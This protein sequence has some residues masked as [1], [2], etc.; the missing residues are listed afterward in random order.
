MG[1]FKPDLYRNFAIGFAI[2]T[3]IVLANLGS[4]LVDK[5]VPSAQAQTQAAAAPHAVG[6]PAGK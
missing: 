3:L 4:G 1:L 2:G 5:A 6:L